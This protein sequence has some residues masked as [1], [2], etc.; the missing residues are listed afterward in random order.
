MATID[1]ENGIDDMTSGLEASDGV[2]RNAT[3]L[4]G[5]GGVAARG[6]TIKPRK[7]PTAFE[8][9]ANPTLVNARVLRLREQ[10]AKAVTQRN[11]AQFLILMA[12]FARFRILAFLGHLFAQTKET[13]HRDSAVRA[14]Q[15][16]RSAAFELGADPALVKLELL[17]LRE[18]MAEAVAHRKY[19]QIL[20][21][22]ALFARL[23]QN[24]P[25]EAGDVI[26]RQMVSDV[27]RKRIHAAAA[28]AL[29][30]EPDSPFLIYLHA[31]TLSKNGGY[32][33]ASRDV[34]Y[35]ITKLAE[36]EFLTD[37]AMKAAKTDFD[38]LRSAWRVVDLIAREDT[39]QIGTDE[40][41]TSP[42][43]VINHSTARA[44][45][46]IEGWSL[47]FKEHLLQSKDEEGYLSA[48]EMEFDRC[49]S[50]IDG[51]RLIREML[52][53]GV[54]RRLTFHRSYETA[55]RC[56]ERVRGKFA[57]EPEAADV[58]VLAE[59]EALALVLERTTAIEICR[60][61]GRASDIE[62]LKLGLLRLAEAGLHPSAIWHL[63]PYLVVSNGEVDAAD[64]VSRSRELLRK[65]GSAPQ[66]EGQLKAFLL[67]A[68]RVRAFEQ[69][70]DVM[71]KV[72]PTLATSP[73]ALYFVN[74][75]QRQSRFTEA[76]V[77]IKG[78]HAAM[79]AKPGR[80][81]PFQHWSLIR[82]YGEL[83]FLRHTSNAFVK[84]PQPRRPRGVI[85][86][87]PRNIDQLR[88]YP[89]VVLIELKRMGW[90]VVPLVEGLLPCELT[91]DPRIDL[92][93]GC[94]TMELGLRPA[95]ARVFAPLEDFVAEPTKGEIRWSGLNLRHSMWEDA[96]INRRAYDI[97]FTC[98]AL[99]EYLQRLCDWTERVAQATVYAYR[100]FTRTEMR[101]GL[102]SLYNS[103]LPDSLF[104]FFCDRY[105][106]P[107]RFFCLQ[108]ANGYE[109]YFTNFSTKISTRCVV[110]NMTRDHD[111]R[112]ASL[113]N[114]V[115]FDAYFEANKH[116]A[117]EVTSRVAEQAQARLARAVP[118]VPDPQAEKC[119]RRVMNWRARGGRVA[120][121][122]GKVVCD[123]AV[124]FDGGPVH[125]DLRDWIRHSIEAV[126]GSTTMLLIKPHPHELN[127]QIA[128]Y[129]NQY[130]A[131]LIDNNIP[132]NVII[133]GHRWFDIG[134]LKEF[135]DLGLIYNGT[136]AVEMAMLGIPCILCN[137]FGPS[138][139]SVG[140]IVPESAQHYEALLRFEIEPTI[141]ADASIR[142]T[143]WLEYMSNGR[144][145]VDYRYHSRPM[146]N[147]VV[148]P[149]YWIDED[150]ASY[151][152]NGDPNVTILAKR[153]VGEVA[154][155]GADER[156]VAPPPLVKMT[157]GQFESASSGGSR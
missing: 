128:T 120:V 22:L 67:W 157:A 41:G 83:S 77:V 20:I 139:Y 50:L 112:S 63:L 143:M 18:Q 27:G 36:R 92:L 87:A 51:L 78:I 1:K 21:L 136:T 144:F 39:G 154:E 66:K 6:V 98:P 17:R 127:E 88:K 149:P 26:A 133:L 80:L 111:L 110:R 68:M 12:R 124:P 131:D 126:R 153:V 93:N 116:L 38:V 115:L 134:A 11:Y 107:D 97:D 42:D 31:V 142:A 61:L 100:L 35:A 130:F 7:R 40:D 29:E 96:R 140:H 102:M 16:E 82:R 146:T 33:E 65:L 19:A 148:Y 9:G 150:L 118:I 89:L 145:A 71:Y 125:E 14:Q 55:E 113:P 122:F 132:E 152:K 108:T 25:A 37:L 49:A 48:C 54:R 129:L 10:M 103:R 123:S 81:N 121:L 44:R 13:R 155:P 8:L 59:R 75:L 56:Y 109:N 106:D 30:E 138:D 2:N 5:A 86:V 76:L 52:R 91:G 3:S 57:A 64:W 73:A 23:R 74:I 72:S 43:L 79:M 137:H 47:N 99:A 135:A 84:V 105:G 101:F 90:A 45:A 104:R 70:E 34:H 32:R 114:P 147:R 141:K 53:Q 24:A 15:R 95:A 46:V 62:E 69:A 4:R 60:K 117:D 119:K 85:V 58:S 28:K 151:F 156:I 94:I